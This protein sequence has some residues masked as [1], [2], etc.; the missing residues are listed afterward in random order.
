M[1]LIVSMTGVA[2]FLESMEEKVS[3]RPAWVDI[4]FKELRVIDLG[5][6]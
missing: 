6:V 1:A 3:Q 2:I 4:L 5:C